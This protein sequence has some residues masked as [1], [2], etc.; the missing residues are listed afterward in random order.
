MMVI[1]NEALAPKLFISL[2]GGDLTLGEGIM[3]E[4]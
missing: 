1:V 3:R 4:S 2:N